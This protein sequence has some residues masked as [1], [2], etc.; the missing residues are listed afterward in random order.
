LNSRRPNI[1]DGIGFQRLE[2]HNARVKIN[3]HEFPK[4]V[5]EAASGTVTPSAGHPRVPGGQSARTYQTCSL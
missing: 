2:K 1:K 5:K 4:F 3:G